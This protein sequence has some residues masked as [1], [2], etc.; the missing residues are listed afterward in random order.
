MIV[1]HTVHLL[2]CFPAL[3]DIWKA[4]VYRQAMR[5]RL[6]AARS[7]Q[8]ELEA[9]VYVWRPGSKVKKVIR[10][11]YEPLFSVLINEK[12]LV[13]PR[14]MVSSDLPYELIMDIPLSRYT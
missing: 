2:S 12:V 9:I 4:W 1:H 11:V 5:L 7:A 10:N 6:T 8:S 14:R 3:L 13:I